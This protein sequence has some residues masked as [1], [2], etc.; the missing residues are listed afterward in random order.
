MNDNL[1]W[2]DG[3]ACAITICNMNGKI[4]YMNPKAADTFRKW[5]GAELVGKNLFDCHNALSR[6]KILTLIQNGETNAYTIEKKGVRKLIYQ[7]P[8]FVEGKVEGLIEF[9]FVLPLE[10][11]HFIREE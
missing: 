7:T 3:I 2:F 8:W 10:M 9:S 6:D 1:I 4:L 5:G 11:P